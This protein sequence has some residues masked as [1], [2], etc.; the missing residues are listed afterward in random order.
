MNKIRRGR[1]PFKGITEP[2][3]RTLREIRLFTIGHGFPP[4][5]KELADVLGISHASAHGQVNQLVLKDYLKREPRKARGITIA[6][7]PERNTDPLKTKNHKMTS[8]L[9]GE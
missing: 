7:E 2:Q 9:K 1:R 5:I 6:R 8:N 4:T 3:R